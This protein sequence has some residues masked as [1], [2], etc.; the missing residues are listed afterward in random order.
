MCEFMLI[1]HINHD[2]LISTTYAVFKGEN[3]QC[4]YQQYW[5]SRPKFPTEQI[6][7]F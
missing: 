7:V 2:L 6:P 3:C 4:W 5:G 1:H